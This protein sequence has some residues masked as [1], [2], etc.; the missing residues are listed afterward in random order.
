MLRQGR[1]CLGDSLTCSQG[2]HYAG[3]VSQCP[4]QQGHVQGHSQGHSQDHSQVTSQEDGGFSLLLSLWDC[5]HAQPTWAAPPVSCPRPSSRHQGRCWRDLYGRGTNWRWPRCDPVQAP[6]QG[7]GSP[8]QHPR[9]S[10][11]AAPS[12]GHIGLTPPAR[13]QTP[14]CPY[15][16]EASRAA[17]GKGWLRPAL[18]R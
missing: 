17:L 3:Q 10:P 11:Y 16:E 1:W 12:T 18:L 8:G 14:L 9:C 7:C 6:A 4:A 15:R 5:P 13:V 2:S